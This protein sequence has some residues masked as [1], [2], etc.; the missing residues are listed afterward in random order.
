MRTNPLGFKV[1]WRTILTA[2]AVSIWAGCQG[3]GDRDSVARN[4]PPTQSRV[5]YS[6]RNIERRGSQANSKGQVFQTYEIRLQYPEFINAPFQSLNQSVKSYV[7]RIRSEFVNDASNLDEET[8]SKAVLPWTAQMH[9]SLDYVTD[10]MASF[11]LETHVVTGPQDRNVEIQSFNFDVRR[12]QNVALGD[13]ILPDGLP[14]VAEL[15]A[16]EI[17]QNNEAGLTETDITRVKTMVNA[18][19]LNFTLSKELITL[20]FSP[21]DL[22][23]TANSPKHV[24]LAFHQLGP[25]INPDMGQ[26][27]TPLPTGKPAK[28]GQSK[29]SAPKRR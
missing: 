14:T 24:T 20:H 6:I 18:K 8:L 2:V 16:Q 15:V 1:V 27:L 3:P 11:S 9:L 28:P 13:I 12:R 29:K 19:F 17:R 22:G 23:E 4:L 7:E 21:V 25:L 5:L 26:L 10:Q